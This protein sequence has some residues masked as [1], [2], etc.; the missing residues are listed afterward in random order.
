[1]P[2][3]FEADFITG[4]V[5]FDADTWT[6]GLDYKL[7]PNQLVYFTHRRGYKAGG[8]N[9]ARVTSPTGPEG[10][11]TPNL[12]TE[13]PRE[14]VQ[15]YEVGIKSM[16]ANRTVRLN[17][18]VF[19]QKYTNFQLNTFT[20][21]QFVV[22]SIRK[23]DSKGAEFDVAWATPLAGLNLSGGVTYAFTNITDF[24][25]SLPLFNPLRLND[26]LSFAPLWSGVVS[27]AYVV[28]ISSSVEFRVSASDKY[29]SSYNTGSDLNP[30]K[31]QGE[32]I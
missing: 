2:V 19:D 9:L 31:L 13:F 29:S 4:P 16:V 18:S 17:A 6:L 27:A 12:N 26:R 28:P 11:L 15:S 10:P 14:T 8:F 32:R 25:G 1:M 22:S 24:G 21:I 30:E 5:S 20:G 3:A 7:T 23:L